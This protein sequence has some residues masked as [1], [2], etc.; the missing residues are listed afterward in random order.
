MHQRHKNCRA[1]K[2]LNE[3]SLFADETYIYIENPKGLTKQLLKL[4]S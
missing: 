3:L 4:I 2:E 1:C